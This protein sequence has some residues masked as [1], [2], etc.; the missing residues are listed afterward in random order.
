[1]RSVLIGLSCVAGTLVIVGFLGQLHRVPDT[2]SIGRPIFGLFC[3]AGMFAARSFWLKMAFACVVAA[4]LFTTVRLLLPQQPGDDLKVYAKNLWFANTEIP[5]LVDDIE[6]TGAD[7]VMLQEVSDRNIEVLRLLEKSYPYQHFCRFSSWSGIALASRHPIQGE[8]ICS[9][10]RAIAAV[11]VVIENSKV[12]LVSVHIPWPWPHDSLNNE[13][14][15][16]RA[17]AD[18]DGALVIAGDFNSMPWSGRVGRIASLTNTRL[19]GPVRPTLK[20]RHVPLPLDF[21]LAPGGGSQEIRPF[22]GSDHAGVLANI[23]LRVP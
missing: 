23:R 22:F 21:V 5:A 12:W 11:P 14:D 1:M 9:N 6:A 15:A 4:A 18:L 2:I 20:L 7:A 19:T 17:L 10:S 8:P 16:E 13:V 3:V